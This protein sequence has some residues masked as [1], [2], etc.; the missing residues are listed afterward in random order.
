MNKNL[1]AT[2][3]IATSLV[4]AYAQSAND[5]SVRTQC[6]ATLKDNMLQ[7]KT[8]GEPLKRLYSARYSDVESQFSKNYKNLSS[9]GIDISK[10][11]LEMRVY[12]FG[13]QTGYQHPPKSPLPVSTKSDMWSTPASEFIVAEEYIVDGKGGKHFIDCAFFQIAADDL[14]GVTREKYLYD[15]PAISINVAST[16]GNYKAWYSENSSFDY[17]NNPFV[18]WKRLFIYPQ[19]TQNSY[20]DRYSVQDAYPARAAKDF[21]AVHFYDDAPKPNTQIQ[22]QENSGAVSTK[23]LI[24]GKDGKKSFIDVPA[25]LSPVSPTG[26]DAKFP[27][28]TYYQAIEA[29]FPE[30]AKL[31][32]YR[33][34][35]SY[36]TFKTFLVAPPTDKESIDLFNALLSPDGLMRYAEN[37]ERAEKSGV[38]YSDKRY[39]AIYQ[40]VGNADKSFKDIAWKKTFGAIPKEGVA[41]VLLILAALVG[42]GIYT[43]RKGKQLTQSA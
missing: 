39:D 38:K 23:L 5:L 35:L 33:G 1:L 36:E 26:A 21:S 30:F 3:V 42:V 13:R 9:F 37:K 28:N 22:M 24:L 40:E 43:R 10:G 11:D 20:F 7:T 8:F 34:T 41:G 29:K 18:T 27:L 32:S 17:N 4:T 2:I 16:T 12:S 15:G 31:L 14:M 19:A 6:F 25:E